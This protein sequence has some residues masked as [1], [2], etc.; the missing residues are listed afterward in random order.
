MQLLE[1]N[2]CQINLGRLHVNAREHNKKARP[3]LVHNTVNN[4]GVYSTKNC[5]ISIYHLHSL[6]L[7]TFGTFDREFARKSL[8]SC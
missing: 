5:N 4:G 7:E 1:I 3:Y 2:F 6:S 8:I